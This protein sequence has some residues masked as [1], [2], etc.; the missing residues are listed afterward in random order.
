M[1]KHK[2]DLPHSTSISCCEYDDETKDMHITF[3]SGGKHR[4]KDV[5]KDVYD[6]LAAAQSPG[7]HFHQH[8]RKN[9]K[10]EKVD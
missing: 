9:Y 1:A 2:K 5:E 3:A 6:G 8:I 7:S 10:S 4:F